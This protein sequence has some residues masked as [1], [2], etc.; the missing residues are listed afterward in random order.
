MMPRCDSS[1]MSRRAV[2]VDTPKRSASREM[3]TIGLVASS[4]TICCCRTD[5]FDRVAG[6]APNLRMIDLRQY[7]VETTTSSFRRSSAQPP[8]NSMSDR[9]SAAATRPLSDF[10]AGAV[11]FL[12]TDIDDTLTTDGRLGAEAYQALEQLDRAGIAV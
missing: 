9:L 6:T 2:S 11:S 4:A 5:F 1:S 12:L 10:P 8:V 3:R 7:Y